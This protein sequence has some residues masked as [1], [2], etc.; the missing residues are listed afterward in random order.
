MLEGVVTIIEVELTLSRVPGH[1][2]KLVSNFIAFNSCVRLDL[3][4]TY[5]EALL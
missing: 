2:C 5:F 4:K 1:I 3:D